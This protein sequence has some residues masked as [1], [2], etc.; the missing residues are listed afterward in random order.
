MGERERVEM[1]P[2]ALLDATLIFTPSL[3][4]GRK[5]HSGRGKVAKPES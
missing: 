2:K 3:G 1:A 5:F 4:R